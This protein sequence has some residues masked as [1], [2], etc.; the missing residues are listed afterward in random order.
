MKSF[1]VERLAIAITVV[2]LF[3]LATRIPVD[4]DTWWHIRSGE[5]TLTQG[6]IYTD[7]FSHTFL[8][9]PWINHSWGAQIVLYGVYQVLGNV[10]LSLYTA[11]LAVGGLVALYPILK[12]NVYLKGFLLILGASAASVFWSARPQM[13]SFFL[14]GFTLYVLYRYKFTPSRF[15]WVLVPMMALW[16]N[17][18][19]GYSIGFIFIGAFIVGESLNT[20]FI[21]SEERLSWREIGALVLVSVACVATLILTPYG[22]NT[23]LVP[24]QTVGIGAL[25]DY[26]QE[27]N[28]P[29]FQ[30]RET[31]GF[32]ILV[33]LLFAGAW[34]S[35]LAFDWTGFLLFSGTLFMAL[36][37]GRNIA[38]FAMAVL[39]QLAILLDDALRVRGLVLT[40]RRVTPRMARLNVVLLGVIMLGVAV[41]IVGGVWS[42]KAIDDAQEQYLPV[43]VAQYLQDEKPPQPLFNSYNWGG[44]L[45]LFAP[46]YPVFID[47]RTDLYGEFLQTYVNVTTATGDWQAVLDQYG[48]NTIAVENG[49]GL[50]GALRQN[51][52]WTLVYEDKMAVIY[53]RN[54]ATP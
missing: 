28:S 45:M 29:N 17:L 12:G 41:Y 36:L 3:A 43:R 33:I 23:L 51:L 53:T 44:Y 10:G 37:Y 31:W 20:L 9:K 38:V 5:Y 46:D 19:A 50:D 49:A 25:R 13:L 22:L 15:V 47:G 52:A 6:M 18:H 8:G 1:S 26:I 24:F 39:P 27:W 48:I 16:A 34:W 54:G 4:S 30:G 11:L 2:L 40:S 7:P 32:I 35:R 42:S 14:S 21:L